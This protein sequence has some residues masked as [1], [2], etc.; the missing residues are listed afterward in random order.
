M[1]GKNLVLELN[2]KMLS[3][4]QIAVFSNFNIS[5]AIGDKVDFLHAGTYL[6]KQQIDD[7]ILGGGGQVWPSMPKCAFKTEWGPFSCDMFIIH[8]NVSTCSVLGYCFSVIVCVFLM[9]HYTIS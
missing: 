2:A 3:A 6:L 5:K 4:N 1:S 9:I 7:V 8:F